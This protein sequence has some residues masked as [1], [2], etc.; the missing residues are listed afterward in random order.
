VGRTLNRAENELVD[1]LL[2]QVLNDHALGAERQGL[3]LDLCKVLDLAYV[4]E[5]G[6][7]AAGL[8]W[9]SIREEAHR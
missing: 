1:K 9:D 6:L 3:L 7:R 8:A 2:L 5:E 4:G